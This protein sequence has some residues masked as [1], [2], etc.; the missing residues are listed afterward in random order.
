MKMLRQ[1][2]GHDHRQLGTGQAGKETAEFSPIAGKVRPIRRDTARQ[3]NHVTFLSIQSK[4]MCWRFPN[5]VPGHLKTLQETHGR[6][7]TR[8]SLHF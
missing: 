1:V 2:L 4:V 7:G 3:Y 5:S 8:D 6:G